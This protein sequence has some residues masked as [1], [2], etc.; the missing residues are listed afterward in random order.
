M[1]F[2]I[3][4]VDKKK[5]EIGF[6]GA[7]CVY[8][9]GRI[10]FVKAELGAISTQ[11]LANFNLGPLFI[12]KL[13]EGKNLVEILNIFREEDDDLESRQIGMVDFEGSTLGFTG[14]KCFDWAGHTTGEGYSCQGNILI[15]SEVIKQMSKAFEETEG[16]LAERLFAALKAG[17]DAG[18]DSRGKQSARIIV[19]KKEAGFLKSDRFLD[20]NVEDHEEPIKELGRILDVF[21]F[22]QSVSEIGKKFEQ[23]KTKAI[24]EMEKFLHDKK[25]QHVAGGW[26]YLA[27]Q[28]LQEKLEEKAIEYYIK[29][30]K[31]LPGF[32]SIFK[33]LPKTGRIPK[34]VVEK[35]MEKV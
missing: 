24:T 12:E 10:G 22:N 20:I 6:A 13:E 25:G 26:S 32:I 4:A 23:D 9:A 27:H 30:I 14:S 18:G 33:Q 35:V 2:S 3:V 31:I 34:E 19:E 28:C 7:S 16:S 11:A 5:K 17:D 1:T 15:G 21:L 29:A 8:N